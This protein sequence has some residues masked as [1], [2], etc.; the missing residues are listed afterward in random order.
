MKTAE[1]TPVRAPL[2]VARRRE[3]PRALWERILLI[4]G[5]AMVVAALII[6]G[7]FLTSSARNDEASYD[8]A[9]HA[10]QVAAAY[11]RAQKKRMWAAAV[12]YNK[13]L[14]SHP[15]NLG[16]PL[17]SRNDFRG[18]AEYNS[19]LDAPG[20][21]MSVVTIPRLDLR[22]TLHHG[23][24]KDVLVDALGHLPGT[25]LPVGGRNTRVV[26]VGH[27]GLP[28][29]TL[30][31]Y[32]PELRDGDYVFLTTLGKTLAYK[33]RGRRVILPTDTKALD[34]VPGK[35]MVTLFTCT[36]Y[37]INTKRLIVNA[38]RT[39][40]PLTKPVPG[41]W[42][43]GWFYLLLLAILLLLTALAVWARVESLRHRLAA[44]HA[45]DRPLH[46]WFRM[47]RH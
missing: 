33:V 29:H 17:G 7:T 24:S 38:Y 16:D 34:I 40:W 4:T 8:N 20:D 11:S 45:Q 3:E 6:A 37:G 12:A 35:D 44:L 25:S 19:L 21:I 41:V 9:Q 43:P 32:L 47:R 15:Q 28:G 30:F 39:K 5:L 2:H 10:R 46:G 31:T 14:A 18:D 23:A 36:P 42:P 22:L 1:R 27:R 26:I 13:R